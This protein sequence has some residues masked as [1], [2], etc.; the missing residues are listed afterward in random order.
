MY[1][2][3]KNI[4]PTKTVVHIQNRFLKKT[5]YPLFEIGQKQTL[6]SSSNGIGY[7]GAGML[8]EDNGLSPFLEDWRF[9]AKPKIQSNTAVVFSPILFSTVSIYTLI[10]NP[11]IHYICSC[12]N[13]P[14]NYIGSI[15]SRCSGNEPA[16]LPRTDRWTHGLAI[17]NYHQSDRNLF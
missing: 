9:F 1:Y 10:F 13:Y 12:T 8:F 3:L 17:V 2:W 16:L 5:N 4:F 15:T 11:Y 6:P 7:F 14:H